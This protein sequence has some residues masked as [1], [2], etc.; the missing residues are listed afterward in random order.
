MQ[1]ISSRDIRAWSK[2]GQKGSVFGVA[3]P[4]IAEEDE[5][6][7]VL[8]ADLMRLSGLQRFHN[9]Y[10]DKLVNVGI[11]EQN[12]IGIASGLAFEGNSVFATTYASFITMRCYEQIRHNLGYQNADVK[13]IGSSSGLVMGFS[14]NTHYTYEDIGIMRMI[15][16]IKILSPC[17]A[18]EAYKMT[19]LAYQTK[20]P[21]YI[22]LSGSLQ[23]PIVYKEDYVLEIG[24]A[25]TLREGKDVVIFTTGSMVSES[26]K[27]AEK[28]AA[29]KINATVVNM[30][31][32]SPL[33]HEIIERHLEASLFVTVEEHRMSGG[34]YSAICEYI[35]LKKRRPPH[36]S[37][38]IHKPYLP[39][40]DYEY[41]KKLC[42]LNSEDIAFKILEVLK[43]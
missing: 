25:I 20:G 34:L 36:L 16:N 3:L 35:S 1:E 40:G 7:Y 10:P 26:L 2:F 43:K 28:L 21:V 14:G 17:D 29:E 11:A 27:A 32:I 18:L 4:R 6:V 23:N 8:T 24:K 15:P 30:H 41:L 22:R 38:G 31:T 39:V 42:G 37:I 12:M 19:Y 5:S 33:D 13:L 9:L